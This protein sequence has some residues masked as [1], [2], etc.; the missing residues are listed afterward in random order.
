MGRPAHRAD[1]VEG[2]EALLAAVEDIDADACLRR[3]GISQEAFEALVLDL[4]RSTRTAFHMSVG[5]NMS[6]FGTIAYVLMQALAYATGNLDAKGGSVF[7]GTTA[8]VR[9]ISRRA[10]LLAE[11]HARVT[12][13]RSTVRSL[14][15][16][17]LADAPARLSASVDSSR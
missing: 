15:G 2:F 11:A 13:F 14:P 10:G 1:R 5:V 16:G 7:A 12:G 3:T 17:I 6:G 9:W 4:Q 8:P